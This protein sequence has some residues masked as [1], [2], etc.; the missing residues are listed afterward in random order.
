MIKIRNVA[1][2]VLVALAIC[3]GVAFVLLN[4][5]EVTDIDTVEI[6]VV[7]S[8]VTDAWGTSIIPPV[9]KYQ[10][11]VI[12]MNGNVHIGEPTENGYKQQLQDA[13][14][15]RSV[16]SDVIVDGQLV[17]KVIFKTPEA[18]YLNQIKNM[19]NAP[20]IVLLVCLV[21]IVSGYLL[22][23]YSR[24][25][26]P[27]KRMTEF[28]HTI[29]SGELEIPLIMDRN[30]IFG[31]YTESFDIMREQLK[32][33]RHNEQLANIAKK[34]LVAS[35]SHDLHA[36]LAVIKATAECM[37]LSDSNKHVQVL[38]SKACEMETLISDMLSSTL[39]ELCE[40]KVLCREIDS[41]ALYKIINYADYS[42]RIQPYI[43]PQCRVICDEVRLNQA[44]CN[45][46]SNAYKYGGDKIFVSL[47]LSDDELTIRV[48]DNGK[49][50]TEEEVGLCTNK[51]FRG[52]NASGE[53][54]AGLGLFITKKL[55]EMMGGG[56][57]VYVDNGFV[58]EVVVKRGNA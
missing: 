50:I 55:C 3:F 1:I 54:G 26:K 53:N 37:E 39:D 10:Y 25:Y 41:S 45:I 23:I 15:E 30:N 32:E 19:I 47:K 44:L 22:Y 24:V 29:A 48:K 42:E 18:Y 4:S 58:A 52:A 20:L 33:A 31:A 51:Y 11:S 40:L 36:P 46:I 12:D 35:L 13:Y 17:G 9:S 34:E 16:V 57:N 8:A 27:F 14:A 2:L 43:I 49:G 5:Q 21:L 56:F 7:T 6:A 38:L 28:A